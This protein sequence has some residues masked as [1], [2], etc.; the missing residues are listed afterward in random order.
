[1]SRWDIDTVV[2]PSLFIHCSARIRSNLHWVWIELNRDYWS[3]PRNIMPPLIVRY[4]ATD[5]SVIQL[6]P[7]GRHNDVACALR[8]DC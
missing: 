2:L 4:S 3:M 8:S 5:V 6:S 7:D 1:M